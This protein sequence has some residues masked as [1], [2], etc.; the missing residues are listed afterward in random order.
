MRRL[1]IVMVAALVVGALHGCLED[2]EQVPLDL[3]DYIPIPTGLSATVYDQRVALSWNPSEGVERYRVYR[4]AGEGGDL[5]PVGETADTLY[6]DRD[7]INGQPYYYSVAAIEEGLAGT[8]SDE[9]RVVPSP[10]SLLINGGVGYTS[11]VTVSL[12]LNA[13][14][15]TSVMKV[16]NDAD[17]AD[18]VWEGYSNS[19]AWNI[20]DGDGVKNVY[21]MFRD[22]SG[23]ESPVVGASITLDT[24]TAV[25]A[26][27][28]TPAQAEYSPGSTVLFSMNVADDETGGTSW[29]RLEGYPEN[30]N[31][32]DNG[33][34]GD[35]T[36]LDGVYE[37]D[38]Q[39][40]TSLRGTNLVVVGNFIDRAGNEAAPFEADDRISFTDPP[41]PVVLL[42]ADD[43]TTSSITMR[44]IA[45]EEEH[46]RSYRIYRRTSPGV[47]DNPVFLVQELGNRQQ[48]RYPDGELKEAQTYYYRVFVVNDLEETA[49]S[50]E[51]A[52]STFDALPQP[53][54][55]DSLTSVGNNRVTLTWS[56]NGNTDFAEYRLYRDTAPGV[57]T[58]SL[59]VDTISDRE[60]TFYDDTGIDLTSNDYYYRIY[61]FDSGGNNSRSNEVSTA[62]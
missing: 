31:L 24:Y 43:S 59:L 3:P 62:D 29:I 11:S 25:T 10:Y 33:R 54:V 44:W 12:A 40:P 34:G 56:M 7:V 61:V 14:P 49:G 52:A 58:S 4:R 60:V 32:Y 50:N 41:D 18:A 1:L 17:L 38:F 28:I 36:E 35:G 37:A 21:A 45:S 9:I 2:V 48:T 15:T 8:R 22:G 55:L 27:T 57:T 6:S 53:V 42:G 16:S 46:F 51:R 30:I 23:A 20:T 39:F 13:P 47:T 26:V 5:L 19:K